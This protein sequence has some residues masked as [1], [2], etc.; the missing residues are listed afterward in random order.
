MSDH[1]TSATGMTTRMGHTVRR[2]CPGK[3]DE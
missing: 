1:E 2:E 3:M